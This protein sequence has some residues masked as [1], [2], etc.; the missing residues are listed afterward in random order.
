MNPFELHKEAMNFSFN[1]KQKRENGDEDAAFELYTKAAE[2]E[3]KAAEFYF[4][5]PDLEP[6]RS[7]LIRSAAF[8]NLKAGLVEQSE[9]FI[10]WGIINTPDQAIKSQFY[11]ALELCMSMKNLD[12]KEVSGN[13]EYI[14]KLRQK[15]LHYSLEPK[16]STFSRAVTLEMISEFYNNYT[17]SFKAFAKCRYKDFFSNRYLDS[18]DEERAATQFQN[19]I[20]PLLTY[21]SFG[22]F[23]FSVATDFLSRPGESQ[24]LTR[25]KSNILIK[26]HEEVFTKELSEEN[27]NYF[28][29]EFTNNEIDEIFR[30]LLNI[31]SNSSEYK[32]SYY[33]REDLKLY[34]LPNTRNSDKKK[35][36]PLKEIDKEDIGFLENIIAHT[37]NSNK[38]GSSRNIILKQEL[39]NY[40]FDFPTKEINNR[41]HGTI[42][43][44]E[45]III[46]INFDSEKGFTFNFDDL[47]VQS[48]EISFEKG[49]NTFYLN[50]LHQL[51]LLKS[52]QAN[53]NFQEQQ[54][55]LVIKRL[56]N[57]PDAII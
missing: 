17:K 28:K 34:H 20:D 15:S 22:S 37:R 30:P 47:N 41:E 46:N 3:S 26:Y 55:W 38:K 51:R 36:L 1:A 4:D 52:N 25:L 49:L 21:S 50:F 35:L 23:K 29:K 44:T 48:S 57:N 7:V 40:A 5:K 43:L 16:N 42:F 31:T 32:V 24:E 33:N 53:F 13:V 54:D 9:R 14:Q 45:E 12:A 8:L 56:I 10:F 39:K 18:A 2:Y 19:I 6:T 27:I 11:E